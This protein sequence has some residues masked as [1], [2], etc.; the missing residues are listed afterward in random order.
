MDAFAKSDGSNT[1][2]CQHFC[3]P[4]KYFFAAKM[5][6]QQAPPAKNRNL[7]EPKPQGA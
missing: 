7:P 6:E 4:S 1:I 3:S 5:P 2:Y